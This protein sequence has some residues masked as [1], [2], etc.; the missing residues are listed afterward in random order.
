MA[1]E[2]SFNLSALRRDVS[3]AKR[4]FNDAMSHTSLLQ[5][6]AGIEDKARR[7]LQ[8][9]NRLRCALMGDCI[10]HPVTPAR[11]LPP[12]VP[13]EHSIRWGTHP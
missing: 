5:D 10:V 13:V 12:D 6:K 9:L 8:A 2:L 11:A 1:L 7:Y 3:S 4:D